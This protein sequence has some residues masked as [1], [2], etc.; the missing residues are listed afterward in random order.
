MSVFTFFFL[1]TLPAVAASYQERLILSV[2]AGRCSLRVEADEQSRT[3]RRSC[4]VAKDPMLQ[5]LAAAFAKTDPPKLEGPYSSLF[6]GRLIDF[7]WLSQYLA[8]GAHK[9]RGWNREKGKPAAMDVNKYVAT[10]LARREVTAQIEETFG[11][12][13][14]RIV[15]VSVE[16]VLVGGFGDVPLYEGEMLS[17]KVPYDAMV[18]FR[19]E[20]R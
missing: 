1:L 8:L 7:P 2:D 14:Y 4:A 10:I 16:K 13:G 20:K 19:L 15:G 17:G 18:W 12:S 9:D 5:T 11:D 6:I 3:L